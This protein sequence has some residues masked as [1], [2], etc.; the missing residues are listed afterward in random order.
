MAVAQERVEEAFALTR[1]L[2]GKAQS[3]GPHFARRKVAIVGAALRKERSQW[4]GC[5]PRPQPAREARYS[6]GPRRVD[7]A[8]GIVRDFA[9]RIV[10]TSS[11]HGDFGRQITP[12]P[13]RRCIST[14]VRW[15]A[16]SWA[17]WGSTCSGLVRGRR[18][19]FAPQ[20]LDAHVMTSPGFEDTAWLDARPTPGGCAGAMMSP[21]RS[22]M[23]WLT[24]DIDLRQA[25]IHGER[26]CPLHALPFT[27]SAMSM[28]SAGRWFSSVVTSQGPMGPAVV[29]PLPLSHWWV[30]I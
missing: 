26:V 21:G 5:R 3:P 17:H 4:N 24:C 14:A 7:V 27:S 13:A 18:A 12:H 10:L 8:G 15:S 6:I 16:T 22:V 30:A 19:A 20:V 11:S 9:M 1:I 25:E 29:E 2:R 23:Y 28:G